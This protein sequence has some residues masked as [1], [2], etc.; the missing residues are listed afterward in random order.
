MS[1]TTENTT[2]NTNE[3]RPA[4]SNTRSSE[5]PFSARPPRSG[6]FRRGGEGG[7]FTRRPFTQRP[8]REPENFDN[9][10]DGITPQQVADCGFSKFKL[11]ENLIKA[12]VRVGFNEPTTIQH[13]VIEY[14][15][16]GNDLLASSKTGSGKTLAFCAPLIA[17]LMENKDARGLISTPTR[18]IA[19]QV[20]KVI[21]DICK[22]LGIYYVLIIGG[23][24]MDKQIDTLAR[25]PQIIIGTPGRINDHLQRG[26]LKL[27][28]MAFAILDEADR[29]LDMGFDVQIEEMFKSLPSTCQKLMFSA[30]IPQKIERLAMRYLKNAK[31]VTNVN[32]ADMQKETANVPQKFIVASGLNDKYKVLKDTLQNTEGSAVIFV[33]TKSSVEGI[34]DRLKEDEFSVDYIHGDCRQQTRNRT[35]ANFRVKKFRILVAT[36][37]VARGL[38]IPHIEHVINFDMPMS[39]DEYIHRIGR[40]NRQSGMDGSVVNFINASDAVVCMEIK[41]KLGV[42]FDFPFRGTSRPSTSRSFGGGNRSSSFGRGRSGGVDGAFGSGPRREGGYSGGRSNREDSGSSFGQNPLKN[43]QRDGFKSDDRSPRGE[44]SSSSFGAS[45]RSFDKPSSDR[46]GDKRPA[47][48]FHSAFKANKDS[49]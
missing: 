33:K 27:D 30:T 34:V 29:M 10:N 12:L 42:E 41:K 11:P 22:G 13:D 36:D 17:K 7:N 49:N 39:F 16:D 24:N 28:K 6:G 1:N 45:K 8:P 18:E 35:I 43:P 38:D 9:I 3:S 4:R 19:T 5:R 46:F 48:S 23:E 31:F 40:T 37:V 15:L 47:K 32:H 26:T 14:V 44:R 2:G 25:N 21:S 20:S